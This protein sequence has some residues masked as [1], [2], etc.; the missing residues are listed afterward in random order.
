MID[1]CMIIDC[2]INNCMINNRMINDCVNDNCVA[3]TDE[4][5]DKVP[6]KGVIPFSS[7]VVTILAI[8]SIVYL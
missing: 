3:G 5:G 2:M 4:R 6:S 8:L 7:I 1:N